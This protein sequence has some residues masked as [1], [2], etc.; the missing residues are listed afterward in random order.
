MFNLLLQRRDLLHL[1]ARLLRRFLLL[2]RLLL[3]HNAVL[4]RHEF[5][6]EVTR[7]AQLLPLVTHLL[8]LLK[9]P[10]EVAHVARQVVRLHDLARLLELVLEQLPVVEAVE[11]ELVERQRRRLVVLAPVVVDLRRLARRER[12]LLVERLLVLQLVVELVLEVALLEQLPHVRLLI[13]LAEAL[14]VVH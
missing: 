2:L 8:L 13:L 1:G 3:L 9:Q 12:K 11:R 5:L 4:L 14:E 6:N 10:L 7:L